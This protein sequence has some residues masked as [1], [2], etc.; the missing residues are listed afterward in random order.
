MG[1][2]GIFAETNKLVTT[3]LLPGKQPYAALLT[4][5]TLRVKDGGGPGAKLRM[6]LKKTSPDRKVRGH[7]EWEGPRLGLL[8]VSRHSG[9]SCA[10][11]NSGRP[12]DNQNWELRRGPY[13]KT[14]AHTLRTLRGR[15]ES[16][17]T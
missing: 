10:V 2:S 13:P 8:P 16:R 1:F 11:T 5:T 3:A 9:R 4:P 7:R 14:I 6:G 15:G 12:R 17:R